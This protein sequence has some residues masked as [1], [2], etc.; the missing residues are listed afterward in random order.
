MVLTEERRAVLTAKAELFHKSV[1]QVMPYLAERGITEEAA[2]IFLLGCPT[3]GEYL[4][5]LAIPYLTPKG[6][7]GFKYRCTD[8]DHGDHKAE[9]L[10]CKKYLY[11]P[12]VKHQL[13][14]AQALIHAGDLACVTEGELDAITIQVMADIPA[15][16]Y[17]GTSSW[18]SSGNEHWPLCFEGIPEVVVIAD[19]D[20]QG[21]GAAKTVAAS[22]GNTARVVQLGDGYDANSYIVD[23]G[24]YEFLER[25]T[26]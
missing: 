19:G 5:R 8:T 3:E 16:G 12:G 14:N 7:V 24:V 9:E 21:R 13:F 10:D 17:P 20:E 6:V 26:E 11:E 2:D 15:V 1:D 22:I 18:Q 23:R 25:I 4:G